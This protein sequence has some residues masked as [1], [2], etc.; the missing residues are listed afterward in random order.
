MK[1]F[2]I[3]Q[4]IL[5]DIPDDLMRENIQFIH[6]LAL[7]PK[8]KIAFHAADADGIISAAILKSLPKYR[9]AVFVPLH[10]SQ[11]KHPEYGAFLSGLNWLAIVDLP[12]FNNHTLEL[13]CD[14]HISNISTIKNASLVLFNHE[15]PSAASILLSYFDK[16][17]DILNDLRLLANLTEITDT[18]GYTTSPPINLP[19]RFLESSKEEQAWLLDDLCRSLDSTIEILALVEGFVCNGTQIFEQEI[20]LNKIRSLRKRR[21]KAK[22]ASNKISVKDAIIIIQ[23][24]E[25]VQSPT[26]IHYLFEKGVKFTCLLYPGKRFVGVSLRLGPLIPDESLN[27]YRVDKIAEIFE[28][29][30]HPRAAGGRGSNL[31][32]TL[33]IIIHYMNKNKFSYDIVDFREK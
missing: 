10:Y 4:N 32:K 22:E 27:K 2:H 19:A 23:G 33:D 13:Y 7:I 11:L 20:Y 8:E 24:K 17:L 29:G 9:E 30:G 31:E 16:S 12:P 3:I 21:E 5:A 14:H 28:G 18:Y 1:E 26:L 6:S 15:A 25:K